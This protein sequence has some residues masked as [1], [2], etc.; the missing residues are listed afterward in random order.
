MKWGNNSCLKFVDMCKVLL[1][2]VAMHKMPY[3]KDTEVNNSGRTERYSETIQRNN[4]YNLVRDYIES[5]G[6]IVRHSKVSNIG[7]E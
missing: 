6:R 5:K 2:M 1:G 3:S 7:M 4:Q